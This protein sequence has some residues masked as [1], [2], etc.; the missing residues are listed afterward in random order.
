[1]EKYNVVLQMPL[2]GKC[3]RC[4]KDL[5]RDDGPPRCPD[6][7]TQYLEVKNAGVDWGVEV[8]PYGKED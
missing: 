4:S 2:D 5:I 6:H 7:G 1:M 3:P 8:N